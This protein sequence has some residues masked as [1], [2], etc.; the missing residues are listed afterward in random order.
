MSGVLDRAE[1][2]LLLLLYKWFSFW[3]QDAVDSSYNKSWIHLFLVRLFVT[4]SFLQLEGPSPTRLQKPSIYSCCSGGN[5][6][7]FPGSVAP[8]RSACLDVLRSV[9]LLRSAG[10]KVVDSEG[11]WRHNGLVSVGQFRLRQQRSGSMG[12]NPLLPSLTCTTAMTTRLWWDYFYSLMK[13]L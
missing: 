13:P 10:S 7:M 4:G 1:V 12:G 3:H 6:R 5:R 8:L 9:R 2:A 11:P